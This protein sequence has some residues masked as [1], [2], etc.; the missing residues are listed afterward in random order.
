M[1]SGLTRGVS[2]LS[3]ELADAGVAA[4]PIELPDWTDDIM[5]DK[6]PEAEPDSLADPAPDPDSDPVGVGADVVPESV[7]DGPVGTADGGSLTMVL[8]GTSGGLEG[9]SDGG[10]TGSLVGSAEGGIGTG[11]G[12]TTEGVSDGTGWMETSWARVDAR[13]TVH[14]SKERTI[15]ETCPG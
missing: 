1:A 7:S 4:D 8:D 14:T 13:S 12:S 3:D 9:V 10:V 5:S 6:L 11:S 2:A 15:V